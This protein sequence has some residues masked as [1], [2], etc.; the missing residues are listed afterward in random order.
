MK[1]AIKKKRNLK[2]I[3]LYSGA[4]GLDIG[5]KQAGLDIAIALD[6]D[7]LSCE[8]LRKNLNGI[9]VIEGDIREITTQQILDTAKLKKGEA[10]LLVGGPPCQPF[11]KSAFWNGSKGFKDPRAITLTEYIRVLK[12]SEPYAFILEN[13]FGLAYKNNNDA[14]EFLVNGFKELGYNITLKVVTAADYGVP[15]MRQRFIIIGTKDKKG[16][17]FPKPTHQA[18]QE[19]S[20]FPN[21]LPYVTASEAFMGL[22]NQWDEVPKELQVNGK[23]GHLLPTI[24][25]GENYLFLTKKRGYPNPIFE[26]RSRYWSFLLK[27]SPEK[28]SWTIQ[29][30]P[31]PYIGPFHWENRRLTINELKRIQTFP[32]DYEFVGSRSQVQKQIGNAVPAKLAEAIGASVV[33]QLA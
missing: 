10:F 15:Q 9:P 7:H 8:T 14:K 4:G 25:P 20:L 28:P 18:N 5:L 2:V 22:K 11:S 13:V 21:L 24:P 29:A 19:Q 1:S 23:W 30:Q 31:G 16:F 6:F 12:E 26:W 3:S 27:L 33:Q 32:D 17:S